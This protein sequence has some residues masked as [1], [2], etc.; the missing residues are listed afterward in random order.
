MAS[1]RLPSIDGLRIT[2]SDEEKIKAFHELR[3]EMDRRHIPG[4]PAEE[5]ERSR[6]LSNLFDEYLKGPKDYSYSRNSV[7]YVS[8]ME[9]GNYRLQRPT[10]CKTFGLEHLIRNSLLKEREFNLD[11]VNKIFCSQ[12]LNHHQVVVGTKCNKV[13]SNLSVIHVII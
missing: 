10:F 9:N 4:T 7:H 13:S 6:V 11:R 8:A 3:V 5:E 1:V 12:W 2:K